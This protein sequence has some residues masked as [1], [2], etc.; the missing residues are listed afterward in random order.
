[1]VLEQVAMAPAR[2]EIRRAIDNVVHFAIEHRPHESI[3]EAI[4]REILKR[5]TSHT[6]EGRY[7][8]RMMHNEFSATPMHAMVS[9]I[10]S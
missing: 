8:R 6:R 7:Y 1:M 9:L 2:Q 5:H 3:K 4:E 10:A